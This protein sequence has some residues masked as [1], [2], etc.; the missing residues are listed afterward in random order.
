MRFLSVCSGIEAASVAWR[1]LGWQPVAFAEIAAF[2]AALLSFRYPDVPNLGD[3]RDING[4]DFRG[5]TDVLVGGTP[6]QSFSV[7]GLRRGLEDERGNLALEFVRIADESAPAFVVWENVPGVLSDRGNAFGCF[8][9]ALAG[10]TSQ[11]EPPGGR[12]ANAGYVLGPGRAIAWRTLDAQY[13]GL[14]QRRKRVFLVACPRSG[15]DPRKVLF[16]YGGL[17]RDSAPGREAGADLAGTLDASL[18]SS[19]GAGTPP[20]AVTQA[21]TGR[22]GE[23]GPDDN[24]AQGGFYVPEI[25]AQALSCKWS[26]GTSGPAGDEHHNLVATAL[27]A[28]GF[29]ASEDGTGRQNLVVAP[30][31]TGNQYGDHE[32]REGLLVPEQSPGIAPM[33]PQNVDM[34]ASVAIRGREGG[35]SVEMRADGTANA[36]RASEGGRRGEGCGAVLHLSAVRRLTPRECERLQGFPDNYT[37]IPYRGKAAADCADGPRYKALGNSMAVPVMRWIGERIQLYG[38]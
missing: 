18:G 24:K 11:L 21:L 13:F 32:S 29:D 19:R 37:L 9:G 17:R 1:P 27:R 33:F 23:G 2:P 16:E 8:L 6:C 25:V 22:M 20:G 35:A 28:E 36:L 34:V 10:E 30:P 12:W 7:A 31:L 38:E 26:K 3:L 15:A 4:A 5:K 14:A